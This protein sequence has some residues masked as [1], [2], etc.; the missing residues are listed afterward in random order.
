MVVVEDNF[1]T[2]PGRSAETK[3]QI[4]GLFA[5]QRDQTDNGNRLAVF[6]SDYKLLLAKTNLALKKRGWFT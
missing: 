3:R 2:H 4:G 5:I 1:D 6:R